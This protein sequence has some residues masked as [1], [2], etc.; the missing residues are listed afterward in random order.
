MM[1]MDDEL[2]FKIYK[3]I[4]FDLRYYFLYTGLFALIHEITKRIGFNLLSTFSLV[5]FWMLVCVYIIYFFMSN[6]YITELEHKNYNRIMNIIT[7][8]KTKNT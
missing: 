2:R 5:V 3:S 7:N 4:K 6:D 8:K 1:K